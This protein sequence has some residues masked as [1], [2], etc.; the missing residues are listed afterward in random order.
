MNVLKKPYTN[1]E[2]ADFVIENQGRQLFEDDKKVWFEDYE[3]TE[4]ELKEA[5]ISE[6]QAYLDE[7]DWYAVRLAETG[8]AIPE[9]VAA[10]RQSAR[11]EISRLRGDD[12]H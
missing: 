5:R 9:D 6:L 8:V 7:T 1:N 12:E 10:A 2:Y 11:E 3:P 4:R